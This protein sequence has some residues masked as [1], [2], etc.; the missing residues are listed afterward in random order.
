MCGGIGTLR[1]AFSFPLLMSDV[2]FSPR[3]MAQASLVVLG[4]VALGVLLFHALPVLML[5]FGGVLVGVLL[6]GLARTIAQR[7]GLSRSVGLAIGGIAAI[8]VLVGAAFLIG[9]PIAEQAPQFR[10]ALMRGIDQLQQRLG[11]IGL[12]PIEDELE[13]LRDQSG[14]LARTA[15]GALSTFLG[16]LTNILVIVIVGTYLAISPSLYQGGL[17][18]LIPPQHRDRGSEV[19][20][21]LGRGLRGWL[22]GRVLSMAIVGLLTGVGLFI[23]GV[24]LALTLGV[25]AFLL[26]FIPYIG[27]LLSFIPAVLVA[28]TEGPSLALW[29]TGVYGGVQLAESYLITPLVQKQ[30]VSLPPVLLILSQVLLG[31]L[32]GL[33]GVAF[34]APIAVSTVILFQMLYVNDVLGDSVAPLGS[35]PH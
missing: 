9:P 1:F 17:L 4:V 20:T 2:S 27:P 35:N 10:E 34:A 33:I 13:T 12:P 6:D 16:G 31:A 22:V 3:R 7:T 29:A 24:P 19:F 5:A 11:A 15:L 28:L 8:L 25:L 26:S 32:A 30:V 18:R 23:V 21:Q 14:A